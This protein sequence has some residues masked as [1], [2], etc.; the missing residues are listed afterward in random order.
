MKPV[1]TE[2]NFEIRLSFSAYKTLFVQEDVNL[3]IVKV[4]KKTAVKIQFK[5]A[6][7][8]QTEAVDAEDVDST[9]DQHQNSSQGSPERKCKT[10]VVPDKKS[11]QIRSNKQALSEIVSELKANADSSARQHQMRKKA[12]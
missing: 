10:V 6:N 12:E 1:F 9:D 4:T 2:T 3:M 11:K 7:L 8:K 5:L